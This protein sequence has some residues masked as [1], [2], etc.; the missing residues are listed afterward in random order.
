[1]GAAKN[2]EVAISGLDRGEYYV[3]KEAKPRRLPRAI[4][5]SRE[6]IV[7]KAK[8]VALL[9]DLG[10]GPFGHALNNYV[11]FIDPKA[12]SPKPDKLYTA[13][14][15]RHRLASTLE[16]LGFDPA[17]IVAIL[18]SEERWNLDGLSPVIGDVIDS[19]LDADRMDYLIRD[20]HMT[21]LTMG[22]TNTPAMLNY[23]R[24]VSDS[25]DSGRYF[26]AYDEAA[27]GYMEHFLYAREAMY[28]NC[29]EHPRKKAAER[30]F[31]RLVK[32]LVED[33]HVP[34]DD[35]YALT[36]EEL[37]CL[38]R[39]SGTSTKRQVN[40]C[41]E[42]MSDLDYSSVYESAMVGEGVPKLL[43]EWSDGAIK[44]L[45]KRMR[46]I[47]APEEWEIAIASASMIGV[48]RSW[49][50]QVIVPPPR[51]AYEPHDNATQILGEGTTG[52]EVQEFYSASE[53]IHTMIK[54]MN[55]Q[56]NKLKVMC[57]A[58]LSAEER[59]S[60]RKAATQVFEQ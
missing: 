39:S 1:L 36:D 16:M 19:S 2:V 18:D 13:R 21:G 40:F 59:D 42:L 44:P 46:Y 30:I 56:R 58:Q 37:L 55:S 50:I 17:E 6:A 25:A 11:G 14:Y 20:A 47:T 51:A 9:H 26:L 8:L 12:P 32:S 23:L 38:V 48:D 27:I 34:I 41:T 53:G 15:I 10:H 28:Y 35:L 49:Q 3:L 60:I 5:D 7:L 29:Y 43:K 57:P 52:Y 54:E 24:L 22:F 31:Q 45:Q 4:I 33:S